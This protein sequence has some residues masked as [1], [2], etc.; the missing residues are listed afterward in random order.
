MGVRRSCRIFE[1]SSFRGGTTT[2]E[3]GDC[4]AA[5]ADRRLAA[6]FAAFALALWFMLGSGT[7]RAAAELERGI[8]PAGRPE[9]LARAGKGNGRPAIGRSCGLKSALL[10]CGCAALGSSRFGG[11]S[12]IF[13]RQSSG[14]VLAHWVMRGR[15]CPAW[16]Q[17]FPA[18]VGVQLAW[19]RNH[20]SRPRAPGVHLRASRAPSRR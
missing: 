16:P 5:V 19:C 7:V 11:M 14:I 4:R 8:H 3:R 9:M 1:R 18:N 20:C 12:Y 2:G 10:G 17:S 15:H 13:S 6:A